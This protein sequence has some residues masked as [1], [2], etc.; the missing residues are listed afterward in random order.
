V[1]GLDQMNSTAS[2]GSGNVRLTFAWGTDLND[3]AAKVRTRVDRLRGRL[4]QEADSPSIQ[5]FDASSSPIVSL[6]LEGNYD[7]VALRELAEQ[8]LG[9]RLERVEGV[10]AV[11]VNGGLRRQIHVELSK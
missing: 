11:T 4:P 6:G 1:P 2:E 3:A 7:R 9:P 10:A 5:K 8:Q